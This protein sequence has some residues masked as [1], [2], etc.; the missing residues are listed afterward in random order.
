MLK[1]ERATG[2]EK[3]RTIEKNNL[4]LLILFML[5]SLPF[6]SLSITLGVLIGAGIVTINFRLLANIVE[7]FL[8]SD[9]SPKL[10]LILNFLL[11]FVF[12]F[13][14]VLLVM[15]WTN[16]NQIALLFGTT[17]IIFATLFKLILEG[18]K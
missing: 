1:E 7:K 16:V 13:G 5:A 3:I 14:S 4:I 11:K 12:L 6:L 8:E 10:S 18:N 15:L 2:K 9:S 17:T